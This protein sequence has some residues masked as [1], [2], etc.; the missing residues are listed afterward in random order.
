M[1]TTGLCP[2]CYRAKKLFDDKG[3]AYEEI[4]V[5]FTPGK[6]DEMIK[7]SGR[8]TV[9]QVFIG[10]THVGGYDDLAAMEAAGSLDPLLQEAPAP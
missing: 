1:Y 6:R 4:D 10:D 9:P 8:R 2:Y 7:R 5:M 3:V